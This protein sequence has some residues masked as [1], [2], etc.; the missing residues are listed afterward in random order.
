MLALERAEWEC[1]REVIAYGEWL[2]FLRPLGWLCLSGGVIFSSAA[3]VSVIWTTATHEKIISASLA[4]TASALTGLHG[5][6]K[7]DS[8]QAECRRM[9]QALKSLLAELALCKTLASSEQSKK[10]DKLVAKLVN[11]IDAVKASP[12]D[13]CYRRADRLNYD[14][15]FSK[16][17]R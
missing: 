3:G 12:A 15:R 11:L 6:L 17:S 7:C 8:H 13:W 5:T 2:G 16:P 4:F 1:R 9:I 10:R 14:D